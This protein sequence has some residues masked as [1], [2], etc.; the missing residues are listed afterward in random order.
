MDVS[1][2]D[3]C[4]N[5]DTLPYLLGAADDQHD[6][7]IVMSEYPKISDPHPPTPIPNIRTKK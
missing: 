1:S 5:Y 4:T 3:L 6:R 2:V 7:K